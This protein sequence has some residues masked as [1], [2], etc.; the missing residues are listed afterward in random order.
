MQPHAENSDFT[1][2]STESQ[3]DP[4]IELCTKESICGKSASCTV[5]QSRLNN[6]RVAIKRLNEKFVSHPRYV[7]AYQ[8]EFAIG[9]Q[10]KHDALPTYRELKVSLNEVYIV[11]DYV[12]GVSVEEFVRTPEGRLYFK[13]RENVSRFLDEL[14]SVL[15]YMHRA[16][17]VHCDLKPSN[18]MLRHSDRAVLLIDLDKSYSDTLDLTH[19][20]TSGI[21][22]PL[23]IGERPTIHKD[24]AAVGVILD[25]LN[26]NVKDFPRRAFMK[27]RSQC[28]ACDA[29]SDKL[30]RLLH[31]DNKS[32]WWIWIIMLV[33]G[34]AGAT[35]IALQRP[36]AEHAPHQSEPMA[37]TDTIVTIVQPQSS[38]TPKPI[39]DFDTNMSS[40]IQ[41]VNSAT[42]ELQSGRLSNSEIADLIYKI[43]E[44]YTAAYGQCV[45]Y[46][47]ERYKQI[48]GG[49][50]EMAVAKASESSR[51]S[52]LL[53]SFTK[54]AADTIASR[55]CE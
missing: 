52:R 55:D 31:I 49:E 44:D 23:A 7:A 8:K 46:A 14:I 4:V 9:Q 6:V 42:S 43:T 13:S 41:E 26:A 39:I 21:S 25:W 33:V 27:L 12:D 35:I 53:Q 15:S 1:N 51:A 37:K 18:I 2:A 5:Y 34:V 28:N 24:L 36:T 3:I 20:G 10:L 54:A 48:P 32:R 19:G 22:A 17:V 11:M 47:K 45:A 29:T 40:F 50:V 38:S 30:K 16:G